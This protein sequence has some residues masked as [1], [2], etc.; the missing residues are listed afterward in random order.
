MWSERPSVRWGQNGVWEDG[1]AGPCMGWCI[2]GAWWLLHIVVNSIVP[3]QSGSALYSPAF[4]AVNKP[5][6]VTT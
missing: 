5:R 2:G 4:I 1:Q 3:F 6:Q